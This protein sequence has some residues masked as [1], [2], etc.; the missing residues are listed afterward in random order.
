MSEVY[1]KRFYFALFDDRLTL[2]TLKMAFIV[3]FIFK[4]LLLYTC[5]S[6]EYTEIPYILILNVYR[7]TPLVSNRE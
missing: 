3:F 7:Q 1:L 5:I 6:L 4:Q 2:K